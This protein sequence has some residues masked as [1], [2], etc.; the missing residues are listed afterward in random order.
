M[1]GQLPTR[2]DLAFSVSLLAHFQDNP[3]IDHWNPLIHVLG[4]YQ[5]YGRPMD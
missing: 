3:G 4:V 5:E 1:W 2:P